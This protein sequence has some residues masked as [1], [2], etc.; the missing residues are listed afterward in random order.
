[1]NNETFCTLA[2]N[3]FRFRSSQIGPTYWFDCLNNFIF[4]FRFLSNNVG[5]TDHEVVIEKVVLTVD[6]LVKVKG[7]NI[8]NMESKMWYFK[9][10]SILKVETVNRRLREY[11]QISLYDR[12]K[13]VFFFGMLS[14]CRET[15]LVMK[16]VYYARTLRHRTRAY[17]ISFLRQST[18]KWGAVAQ[19]LR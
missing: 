14:V 16:Y 3:T 18:Y 15:L 5:L 2:W 17:T 1:M 7:Y 6:C 19:R 4:R 12:I 8:E 11:D 9:S 13:S 10:Y